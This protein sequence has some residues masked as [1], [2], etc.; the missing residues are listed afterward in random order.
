MFS[1]LLGVQIFVTCCALLCVVL[2]V[3]QRNTDASK[4]LMLTCVCSFV[5][6]AG[7]ILELISSN[8]EEAMFAIRIEYLGGAFVATC[9]MLFVFH[10]CKVELLA[11]V[12][13]F[14]L[15][16]D[17]TALIGVWCYKYTGIYY[18]SVSF[19][20]ETLIK[21]VQLGKGPIYL[22]FSVLMFTEFITCIIVGL[23]SAMRSNEEQMKKNYFGIMGSCIVPMFFYIFGMTGIVEG[24][25]TA[26][27]G[28]AIGIILFSIVVIKNRVFD[29]VETAKEH[30]I[31]EMND[32][33]VILDNRKGFRD[34]NAKA[35]EMFP[36]IN[37][38][39]RGEKIP[40]EEFNSRIDPSKYSEYVFQNKSYEFH[41]ND[42]YSDGSKGKANKIL[43]GYS[44]IIIDVTQTK[45]HILKMEE[46]KKQADEANAAKSD[47]LANVSHEIRTPINTIMGNADLLLR[48]FQ[49]KDIVNYSSNI[50][51]SSVILMN[52]IDDI[53]DLSQIEVGRTEINSVT[54][55]LNKF[56]KEL[57]AG[58]GRNK[59]GENV[60]FNY[61]ISPLIPVKLSGDLGRIRQVVNHLLV[62]AF[63]YTTEGEV[64]FRAAFEWLDDEHGN[65]IFTVEDSG[66]GIKEE[67]L[68]RIFEPGY[69]ADNQN[70]QQENCGLRLGICKKVI[71]LMDGEI[72]VSSEYGKGSVFTAI[73]PQEVKCSKNET[74]GEI[75]RI[76]KKSLRRGVGY[77]AP[78]ARVLIVD[79][80]RTNLIVAKALL[81]D[82]KAI[83]D[84]AASGMECLEKVKDIF[85]DVIF[86]DHRM[87]EMDGVETL[88]RLKNEE[89]R[90]NNTSII[91][92]TANG[93]SDAKDYY[94]KEGFNDFLLKPITE[95]SITE[96]L[97][98]HLDKTKVI[99]KE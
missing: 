34:A 42:V 90:T 41:V 77:T 2:L 40:N 82:T 39:S 79:D 21:H 7:Y 46:M 93:V 58:T 87:P 30:L 83:V 47:F 96:M 73:I 80:T 16:I 67:N 10:Y 64:L 5:Q 15:A 20:E 26:P 61:K 29:V 49:D 3:F 4:L 98:N 65:L 9:M 56:F 44:V 84:V 35:R 86:L 31:M 36:E 28:G 1:A 48:D 81:R 72:R 66:I 37:Y 63:K 13:W 85:Y 38:I 57:I 25:D 62:N 97:R 53:L 60:S 99:A 69:V 14:V 70:N 18:S 19:C 6:N 59:I 78:S 92:L 88:H 24:L 8:K 89:N 33:I 50:K 54:Y 95:E 55:D 68:E 51:N 52:L 75:G 91:M 22:V 94:M 74:I 32:A 43:L 23:V 17:I 12:K 71:N 11:F 45:A 27:L 76:E